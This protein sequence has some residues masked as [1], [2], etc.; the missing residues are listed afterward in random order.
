MKL[1]QLFELD[2]GV[3]VGIDHHVPEHPPDD[4][5][6]AKVEGMLQDI[7]L[8]PLGR[9][10]HV[11]DVLGILHQLVLVLAEAGLDVPHPP[12]VV[13]DLLDVVEV[14]HVKEGAE[15]PFLVQHLAREGGDPSLLKNSLECL[16]AL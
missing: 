9:D 5:I 8:Q 14:E 2:V 1:H 3:G 6:V 12:G 15:I 16:K 10:G 4:G 11:A 7:R 13:A